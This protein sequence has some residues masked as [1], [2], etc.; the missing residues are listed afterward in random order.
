M[1]NLTIGIIISGNLIIGV[2]AFI[3][4]NKIKKS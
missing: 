4:Y 2:I 1:S 3:I